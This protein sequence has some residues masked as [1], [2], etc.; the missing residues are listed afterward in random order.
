[1][2]DFTLHDKQSA[3]EDS[4]ALLDNSMD[5]FGM[6]PNLHAV[7]AEA[8]GLLEGYQ[9]LHQLFLDSSFDDE[10]TTVVWQTINV[11]HNC[12]YCVPAHTG[13][14]KSM[15]VDDAI[16]EALRNETPL[17]TEKLEAL[18]NFTLSV[19]RDRVNVNDDAVQAFLNAGFTKRQVLEVILAAAQ[20][21]MSNYT[22]HLAN[23]PI[24]KP[25]QKFEWQKAD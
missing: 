20:K 13:I 6:I 1:M 7:M 14:A 8:P 12:H 24:D 15:K 25:F 10:E 2:T 3:P 4:K 23:T 16:T 5:A 9:R 19:V 11:E 17:P 21:V 18:R 22:N